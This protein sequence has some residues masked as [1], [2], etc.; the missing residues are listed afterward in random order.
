MLAPRFSGPHV[1]E[2]GSQ[3]SQRR[4]Q[5]RSSDDIRHRLGRQ[6]VHGPCGRHEE[7]R[8]EQPA[9]PQRE[10][11]NQKGVAAVQEQVDG[12]IAGTLAFAAKDGIVEQ[13]G[14][15]RDRPV[16]A[17]FGMWP[18]VRV[19]KDQVDVVGGGLSN[20]GIFEKEGLVLVNEAGAEG[21]GIREQSKEAE[22]QN[23]PPSLKAV[24]NRSIWSSRATPIDNS[25]PPW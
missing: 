23:R 17:A 21:V 4:Q 12:V 16:Q 3:H 20:A 11:V 19:A 8:P 7:R 6:G 24:G 18:P 9:Q 2:Q 22:P 5:I 14:E 13:I 15:R 10:R 25:A 1:C